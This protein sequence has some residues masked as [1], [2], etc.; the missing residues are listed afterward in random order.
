[1]ETR[2]DVKAYAVDPLHSKCFVAAALCASSVEF[3]YRVLPTFALSEKLF[4]NLQDF[5]LDAH[6]TEPRLFRLSSSIFETEVPF[7]FFFFYKIGEERERRTANWKQYAKFV[8]FVRR[9]FNSRKI[10]TLL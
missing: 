10:E 5:T 6:R 4:H 7:S 3:N 2:H 1:M 8:Y 9:I